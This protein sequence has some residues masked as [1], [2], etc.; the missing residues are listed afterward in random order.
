M[1]I[2]HRTCLSLSLLI[3]AGLSQPVTAKVFVH[4][5]LLHTAADFARMQANYQ[6][7]PWVGSWNKLV[8]NPR[9]QT[10]WTPRPVGTVIR[11]GTGQNY[12]QFFPDVAAAYQ[13]ALRW[14]ISGDTAYANQSIRI[15][16]AWSSSGAFRRR[17]IGQFGWRQLHGQYHR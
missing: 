7:Q 11:G 1:K 10:T 4:P 8:A 13:S 6:N 17:M 14:K 3:L 15:M 9:S 12:G 5:G 2:K 16:N